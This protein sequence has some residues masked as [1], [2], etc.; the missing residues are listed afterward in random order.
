[1]KNISNSIK[2]LNVARQNFN[3]LISP[4]D[5]STLNMI[6]DGFNNNLIW[7][8]GHVIVT[9]QLLTYALSGL[10]TP[11]SKELIAKYKKGSRP[12]NEVSQ[13]EVEELIGLSESLIP[14]FV[15]DY[16]NGLFSSFGPYKTSFG[17]ELTSLEDAIEFNNL[18]EGMHIG[19]SIVLAQRFQ[20]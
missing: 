18:H 15:K 19:T 11:I 1:M 6:P 20:K 13:S 14:R 5:L 7:N 8:F 3:K 4:F 12:E 10:S 17:Y 9:Q 16:E 2:I